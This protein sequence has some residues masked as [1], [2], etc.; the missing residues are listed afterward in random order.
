MNARLGSRA[1]G[2]AMSMVVL[3]T[4]TGKGEKP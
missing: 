4:R 2:L 3:G 1:K